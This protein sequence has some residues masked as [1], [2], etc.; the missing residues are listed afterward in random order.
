MA[1]ENE[2]TN[3]KLPY[4]SS[5][6]KVNLGAKDFEELAKAVDK[7]FT[8]RLLV[9]KGYSGGATLKSGEYAL[10][11]KSGET[12]TLPSAAT[13]NQIIG[14]VCGATATSVQVTTSGGA[15]IY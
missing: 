1:A 13:A 4:P 12:F 14:V 8:D 15:A 2:T 6:G 9:F 5:G 10:Q 7:V 3:F 11:L